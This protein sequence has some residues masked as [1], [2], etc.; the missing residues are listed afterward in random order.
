MILGERVRLRAIERSDIPAFVRWF[1]D[2]EVRQYLLMYEP[3]SMAAEERWFERRLEAKDD[4]LFSFEG[5]VDGEWIH[6]GNVGLHR[7]DWKNRAATLGIVLGEKQHWSKG[8]GTDVIRLAL[9]FAFG[10]LNLHRVE[11][12]VF[13]FNPRAIHCYEKAGFRREGV[14]RDAF[15]RD[16]AYHD[17]YRMAVLE[18]EPGTSEG[19]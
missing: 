16:G 14:L 4:Y 9:K 2:P 3:M 8:F 17:I 5:L 18:D 19:G 12:D 7:V 15:Y 1:N 10:E 13:S 6:L 11:L